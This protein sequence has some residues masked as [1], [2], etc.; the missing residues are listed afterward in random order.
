[1]L[2]QKNLNN[3]SHVTALNVRHICDTDEK[4]NFRA[5]QYKNYLII[6]RL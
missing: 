4:F 2:L 6:K 3:M 1:M 5:K